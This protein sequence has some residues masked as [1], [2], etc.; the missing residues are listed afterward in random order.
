MQVEFHILALMRVVSGILHWNKKWWGREIE[1]LVIITVSLVLF[2]TVGSFLT[3]FK[4]SEI[5]VVMGCDILS[6]IKMLFQGHR[7]DCDFELW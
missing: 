3:P 4:T 7:D 6:L 2:E 1:Q 5:V